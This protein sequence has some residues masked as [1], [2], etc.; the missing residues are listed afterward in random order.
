MSG[1]DTIST[2]DLAKWYGVS[3]VW[4]HGCL[5]RA[6]L[7]P[8]GRGAHRVALWDR[9]AAVEAVYYGTPRHARHQ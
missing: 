2:S 8:V 5:K 7:K 9:K 6:G 4:V 3:R 1:P